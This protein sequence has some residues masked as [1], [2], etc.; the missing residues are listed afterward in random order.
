M[1][2][3]WKYMIDMIQKMETMI[4]ENKSLYTKI[5]KKWKYIK[6]FIWLIWYWY[7]EHQYIKKFKK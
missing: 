1:D 2:F 4:W 7:F 5:N 6:K 3:L